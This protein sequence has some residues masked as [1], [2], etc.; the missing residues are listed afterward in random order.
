MRFVIDGDYA[1]N[2]VN[3]AYEK[4]PKSLC[5]CYLIPMYDTFS[6]YNISDGVFRSLQY[7]ERFRVDFLRT[8][9]YSIL[10][11]VRMLL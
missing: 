10:V 8:F 4:Q 7:Q 9:C 2:T 3:I 11:F 6:I 1:G 5:E